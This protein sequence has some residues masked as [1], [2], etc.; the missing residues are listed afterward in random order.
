MEWVIGLL[1][2]AVAIVVPIVIYQLQRRSTQ[3][4]EVVKLPD[5]DRPTERHIPES[6]QIPA[7]TLSGVPVIALPHDLLGRLRTLDEQPND[8]IAKRSFFSQRCCRSIWMSTASS[9]RW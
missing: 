7:V 1:A 3:R 8:S 4:V 6:A 2:I 9:L 5:Q